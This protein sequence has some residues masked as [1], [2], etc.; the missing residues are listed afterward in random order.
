[1]GSSAR[2]GTSDAPSAAR[3]PIMKL[4]TRIKIIGP[5]GIVAAALSSTTVATAEEAKKELAPTE[6]PGMEDSDKASDAKTDAKADA[7]GAEPARD[8][9]SPLEIIGGALEKVCLDD[10]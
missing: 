7:K 9:H 5:I 6:C 4:F 8:P 1:M 3:C 10:E 2:C